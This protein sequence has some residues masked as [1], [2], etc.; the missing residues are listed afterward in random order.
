[1]RRNNKITYVIN[2]LRVSCAAGIVDFLIFLLLTK[3]ITTRAL[4]CFNFF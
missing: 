4:S 3:D 1:M 2:I